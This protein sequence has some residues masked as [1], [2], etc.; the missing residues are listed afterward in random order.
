MH[1]DPPPISYDELRSLF[2]HLDC[3]AMAGRECD[4]TYSLTTG[5][6]NKKSLP[7][8]LML[9]W[10]GE[11]GAGCDCEVMFNVAQVWEDEVGYV[12]PD[13]EDE[14]PRPTKSWWKRVFG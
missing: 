5:F 3:S 2:E 9:K 13:H 6:L 11:N 14:E 4:H 10:L 8:D 12:A 1:D 7:V